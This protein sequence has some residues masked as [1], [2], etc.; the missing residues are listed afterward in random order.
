MLITIKYKMTPREAN[1]LGVLPYSNFPS[2]N[3]DN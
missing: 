2:I 3:S 1:S